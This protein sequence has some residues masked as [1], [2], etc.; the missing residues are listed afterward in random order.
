[1]PGR[2]KPRPL[3]RDAQ[4]NVERIRAAAR[5]VFGERGLEATLDDVAA[6]A[7]VGVGTVYRRYP[8]KLALLEDALEDELQRVVAMVEAAA[9]APEAWPAL[10]ALVE[11]FAAQLVRSHGLDDLLFRSPV[12]QE[13]LARANERIRPALASLVRRAKDEGELR[14]DFAA[15]DLRLVLGMVTS[16]ARDTEAAAHEVWPRCLALVLDGMR[17][18]RDRPTPLPT[19]PLSD[20]ELDRLGRARLQRPRRSR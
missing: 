13:H 16:V 18:R 12:A 1:M 15:A 6:R 11:R 3:R 10:A 19:R 9:A 14:D 7:G 5:E 2:A 20:D 17:Q 8:N 4:R